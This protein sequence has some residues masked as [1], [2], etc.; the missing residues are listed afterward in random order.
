MGEPLV[1]EDIQYI[2]VDQIKERLSF[3][4]ERLLPRR[5]GVEVAVKLFIWDILIVFIGVFSPT[6]RWAG[7]RVIKVL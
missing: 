1:S 2:L 7:S 4:N 5:R 3:M 6:R